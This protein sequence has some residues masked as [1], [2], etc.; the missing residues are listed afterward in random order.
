MDFNEFFATPTVKA[1]LEDAFATVVDGAGTVRIEDAGLDHE[2]PST[3][4]VS[5]KDLDREAHIGLTPLGA[6]TIVKG[7]EALNLLSALYVMANEEDIR[8][9]G[10]D[11]SKLL[12][13]ALKNVE[14]H[15]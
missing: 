7:N 3:A 2:D 12:S 8:M 1:L 14:V 10:A 13:E 6:F 4:Y 11:Y 9:T 15:A 5:I